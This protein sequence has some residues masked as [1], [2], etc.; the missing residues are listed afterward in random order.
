MIKVKSDGRVLCRHL[1]VNIKF[2]YT[3]TIELFLRH[4]Y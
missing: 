2:Y 3:V 4:Y 1:V